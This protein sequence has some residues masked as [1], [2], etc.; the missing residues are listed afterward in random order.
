MP[1]DLALEFSF[2]HHFPSFIITSFTGTDKR[3]DG[4]RRNFYLLVLP[5]AKTVPSRPLDKVH[6]VYPSAQGEMC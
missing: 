6:K 2:H 1:D 5:A 3:S 4:E